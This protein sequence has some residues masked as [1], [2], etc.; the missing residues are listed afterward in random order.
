MSKG[1]DGEIFGE[2]ESTRIQTNGSKGG[3]PSINRDLARRLFQAGELSTKQIASHLKCHVNTA[4]TIR[5]ELEAE[6]L[7]EKADREPGLSIV[8]ADFDDEC[9]IAIG[10]SFAEW[11]KTRTK[12]H[13]RIFNFCQ[14]TWEQV[15]DRPSL[16]LAK[17]DENRLGD[18]LCMKFL[19]TFGE[20]VT[21]MRDR[22]KL[23]RNLFRFL[24][25][26]DLC[27]RY[28]TMTQSRD[29]RAIKRIPQIE[30][31]DFP[32]Q[33]EAMFEE[34][35]TVNPQVSLGAE[36]KLVGQ[37][38][39]GDVKEGRG[40]MGIRVGAGNSSYIIMNGPDD[41]R[42]HVLEKMR[43]EWD[44]SW[45]PQTI[46][47]R[48][49]E[50]YQTRETGEL[51][52]SFSKSELRNLVGDLSEKHIGVRLTPHDLRKVSITWLFVMGVPLELAVMINVGWKDLNTPKDHY[53]HMRAL[54]K[55][56]DRKAYAEKIPGW[57]KDGLDE[58]TES[59]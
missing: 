56:S 39:T 40:L 55:R 34:M 2:H 30:M 32:T 53:L 43:E 46:R 48:L 15:W 29:P 59:D 26:R 25:R 36:F 41:I 27:D 10:T 19:D 9:R 37:L 1:T 11:L 13:K 47:E 16:I 7:L 35:R 38:R 44:I 52:F 51:L 5:R 14:R 4:R 31:R 22:K 45:C 58:Y 6:G 18:Q 57:Y 42:I 23:I 33:I 20:D 54:L 21:R 50:L 24:G 12:A 28:L 17:D 8:Q 3:R 49:W